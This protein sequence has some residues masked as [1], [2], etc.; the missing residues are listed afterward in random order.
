L[1]E[2]PAERRDAFLR[3]IHRVVKP[4]VTRQFRIRSAAGAAVHMRV[5][6]WIATSSLIEE[7]LRAGDT[8]WLDEQIDEMVEE[9][10]REGCRTVGFG[11]YLSIVSQNC[12]RA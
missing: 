2:I 10:R 11:G 1:A 6:S 3:G 8:E 12:K 4:A 7:A 9:M 5:V